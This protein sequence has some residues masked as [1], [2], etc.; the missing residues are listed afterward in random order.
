MYMTQKNPAVG[1]ILQLG[2]PTTVPAGPSN[3]N[4]PVFVHPYARRNGEVKAHTRSRPDENIGNN[5]SA[6]KP[7]QN[8]DRR[9]SPF[10]QPSKDEERLPGV[11]YYKN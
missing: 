7:I 6:Q 9:A 11:L 5:F 3:A 1:L 2:N 4:G 10:R 8:T